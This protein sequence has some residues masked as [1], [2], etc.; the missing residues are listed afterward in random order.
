MF[1]PPAAG[2]GPQARDGKQLSGKA[3]HHSIMNS[4]NSDTQTRKDVDEVRPRDT[5]ADAEAD[6]QDQDPG[7]TQRR[8]H[9]DQAE[10]PLAA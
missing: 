7:E 2:A 3:D 10:D 8:N 5:D 6:M 9:H 4:K 1:R